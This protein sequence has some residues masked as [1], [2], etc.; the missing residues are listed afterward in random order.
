[1]RFVFRSLSVV[2]VWIRRA[3]MYGQIYAKVLNA[4]KGTDYVVLDA[5][6]HQGSAEIVING[7]H[8]CNDMDRVAQWRPV[9]AALQRLPNPRHEMR[10]RSQTHPQRYRFQVNPFVQP[11][12]LVLQHGLPRLAFSAAIKPNS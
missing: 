2:A 11:I 10:S 9:I 3:K 12:R 4:T 8:F 6:V 5:D 7:L 1:M